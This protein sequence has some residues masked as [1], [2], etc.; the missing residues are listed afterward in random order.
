MS[1]PKHAAPFGSVVIVRF[2]F[3]HFYPDHE[4]IG[5]SLLPSR[6]V[7]VHAHA[8]TSHPLSHLCAFGRA[9]A[10]KCRPT[11]PLYYVSR[12]CHLTFSHN[13]F[14][15]HVSTALN[16]GGGAHHGSL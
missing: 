13:Q 1:E 3:S 2:S 14:N 8:S 6:A 9:I 5:V 11:G 10:A 7:I 12:I 16:R 15:K 4:H